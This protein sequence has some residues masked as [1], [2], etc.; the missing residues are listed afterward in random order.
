VPSANGRGARQHLIESFGI[1]PNRARSL[2]GALATLPTSPVFKTLKAWLAARRR[3]LDELLAVEF[4]DVEVRVRVLDEL[5]PAWNQRC[6]WADIRRVCVH[7]GGLL[8]SDEIYLEVQG[9]PQPVLILT[10]ARGGPDFAAAVGKRGLFP[11]LLFAQVIGSTSGE[12]YC[13]PPSGSQGG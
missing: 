5:E 2:A 8:G 11:P 7:D 12:T 9:R 6:Y 10:E 1:D 13:W 3:P 4:D